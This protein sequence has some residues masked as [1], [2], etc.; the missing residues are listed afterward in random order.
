MS[1]DEVRNH[2]VAVLEKNK[3]VEVHSMPFLQE[4]SKNGPIQDWQLVEKLKQFSEDNE[5]DYVWMFPEGIHAGQAILRFWK[6]EK[7][8]LLKETHEDVV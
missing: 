8:K 3:D 6:K 7:T 1:L 5:L 4:F 2:I